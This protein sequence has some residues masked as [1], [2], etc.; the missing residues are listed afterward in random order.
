MAKSGTVWML[1][2]YFVGN[3]MLG[4]AYKELLEIFES[5]PSSL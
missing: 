1:L 5:Q 2:H 3:K 4:E